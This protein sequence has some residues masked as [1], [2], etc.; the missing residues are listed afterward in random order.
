MEYPK[1]TLTKNNEVRVLEEKGSYVKYTYIDPDTGKPVKKGKYSL[2]LKSEGSRKR[3]F[4]IP[5][6]SGRSMVV[7][8]D[9]PKKT[10]LFDKEKGRAVDV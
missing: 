7:R 2:I 3:L 10:K 6:K 5:L 9:V 1:E 8:E 4:M